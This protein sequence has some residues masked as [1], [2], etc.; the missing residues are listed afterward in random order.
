MKKSVAVAAA[1]V[2][3]FD[4][5][6]AATASAQEIST[7]SIFDG[8]YAGVH[9]GY[10]LG[11]A[12]FRSAPYTTTL[13]GGGG[14][15]TFPGR[16]DKFEPEGGLVGLHLGHNARQGP[17]WLVGAEA[18]F[19]WGEGDDGVFHSGTLTSISGDAFAYTIR[20]EMDLRWQASLRARI[21]YISGSWL[22]YATGGVAFLKVDWEDNVTV[23]RQPPAFFPLL[24]FH[25]EA[26]NV[27]IGP[28]VGG[29][30]EKAF[31]QRWSGRVEYL[32]EYFYDMTAPHG[33]TVPAQAGRLE[34]IEA[35]KFRFGL[36]RA[37]N[38]P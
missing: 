8:W 22:F 4:I 14:A 31:G 15:V 21:G 28:V 2:S 9:G 33:V 17:N 5:A 11:D 24:S 35:H 29:G 3:L 36:S 18:D 16:N 34:D 12:T 1:A 38:L 26:S 6:A 37:I 32:Y 20:S 27:N 10:R 7:P 13:P 19:T 30:I 23:Q 25:N